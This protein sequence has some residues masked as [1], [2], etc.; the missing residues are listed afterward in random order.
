[1]TL[2]LALVLSQLRVMDE[3]VVKGMASQVNCTGAGVICTVNSTGIVWTIDVAGGGGSYTLPAA[4]TTLGGVKM[5]AP[6]ASGWHVSSIGTGGELT[7]TA[8]AGGSTYTLPT[9]SGATKGGVKIGSRLTMT[10]EVLSA[11]VQ[12][13]SPGGS[14][15][16][17]Q[18]NNAGAF[19]GGYFYI[20]SRG[21]EVNLVTTGHSNNGRGVFNI[22]YTQG[23][24]GSVTDT[25]VTV[26]GTYGKWLQISH[27]TGAGTSVIDIYNNFAGAN[28]APALTME[29]GQKVRFNRAA[30]DYI[31]SLAS[32]SLATGSTFTA[33]TF[34]G[35]LTGNASTATALSTTG[36]AG[37]FWANN[38]TWQTPPAGGGGSTYIDAEIPSGAINGSNVTYTLASTPSP[39]SSLHLYANGVRLRPTTDYSLSTATITM[40]AAL[41]TGDCS[42]LTTAR[43][44]RATTR[45]PRSRPERSTVA[46]PPSPW[47]TRRILAP[48]CTS[49]STA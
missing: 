18:Y 42:T 12:T 26:N 30:G 40:V 9:A 49:T 19:A 5:A 24:V 31:H 27:P 10:G 39:A 36:A 48:R 3:G 29:L 14:D 2:L 23:G 28:Y 6:C 22:D 8:D 46:T 1:L 38:N 34:V 25:L 47:R 44:R 15:G 11:D 4:S 35:A 32:G 13:T 41:Q 45:T 33:P 20:S 43:P 21:E 37:T 7:C 16:S 17:F